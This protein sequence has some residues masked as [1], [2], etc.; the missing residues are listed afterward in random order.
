MG[1]RRV[2]AP[3]PLVLHPSNVPLRRGQPKFVIPSPPSC[4]A[5][6]RLAAPP[7]DPV[8]SAVD[9]V[10]PVAASGG[11]K[12]DEKR[13]RLQRRRGDSVA[14][15]EMPRLEDLDSLLV[16]SQSYPSL[17]FDYATGTKLEGGANVDEED[18]T[19]GGQAEESASEAG[20]STGSSIGQ[21]IGL[22]VKPWSGRE[23]IL[24]QIAVWWSV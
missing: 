20:Q 9:H 14:L 11:T 23:A 15:K 18:R 10:Q 19:A 17:R 16:K 4:Q 2:T 24:P 13:T 6:C 7:S 1:R 8:S 21:R 3:S 12:R 22:G 5:L